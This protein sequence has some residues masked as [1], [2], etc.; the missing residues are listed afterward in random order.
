MAAILQWRRQAGIADRSVQP[1]RHGAWARE[2]RKQ[3]LGVTPDAAR[4]AF[5]DCGAAMPE[6]FR[7]RTLGGRDVR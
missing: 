5:T 1:P 7:Q 3:V 2:N 6:D 4:R